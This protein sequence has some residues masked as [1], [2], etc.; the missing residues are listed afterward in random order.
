MIIFNADLDNTLIYSYKRFIGE[1][2]SC[3]EIYQNREISFMSDESM[4]M[5][6]EVAKRALF[7][8]TTT[9]T[10][11]QFGRIDFRMGAIKYALVCNG[12]VLLTGGRVDEEWYAESLR[13]ISGCAD[14]LNLAESILKTDPDR[15]FELRFIN[16]LFVFTKSAEPDASLA[17][18]KS[19]LNEDKV[20]VFKNGAKVYVVPKE[21]NKGAAALRLKRRLGA[22]KI[23]AA[24]DSEF[25]IPLLNAAD[26]AIAPSGLREARGISGEVEFMP[27]GRLFSEELLSFILR[28]GL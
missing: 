13:L 17:R 5:L 4:A 15:N 3:V 2:K 24:G 6:K 11:E 19:K 25:D 10:L 20:D 27:E 21:L 7:V 22:E 9:R 28:L 16:E 14:E 8:P 1:R 26:I 12:G 18:L 23:I